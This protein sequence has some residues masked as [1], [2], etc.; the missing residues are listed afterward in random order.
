MNQPTD[1]EKLLA[2]QQCHQYCVL[3]MLYFNAGHMYNTMI[4]AVFY[5]EL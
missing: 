3:L 1:P 4:K 5:S 2:V